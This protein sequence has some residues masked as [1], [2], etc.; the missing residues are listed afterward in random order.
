MRIRRGREEM[1]LA[2]IIW[3]LSIGRMLELGFLGFQ[4]ISKVLEFI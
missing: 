4:R 3:R 2:F 1:G